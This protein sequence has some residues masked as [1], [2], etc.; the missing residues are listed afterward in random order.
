[1]SADLLADQF[2]ANRER[3]RALAYRMLGSLSDA[4]DAVQ[5]A[6]LRLQRADASAVQNLSAWLYTVVGRVCADM[7]RSRRARREEPWQEHLPEPIIDPPDAI[8]PEHQA[9]LT[10][11]VGLALLVVLDALPPDERL[12]YVLHD[13]FD[14]PFDD[15]AEVA[16]HTPASARQLASRARRRV[17][18]VATIPDSNLA[19]Q[20]QAVEAFLAASRAGDFDALV[21]VLD[22]D[23]EL[24]ADL[25]PGA[26]ARMRGARRV[27]KR[28]MSYAARA[29]GVEPA[30]IN[31]AAGLVAGTAQQV[32][33]VMGFIV[34][35]GR[36]VAID[37]LGD[38]ARLRH[39]NPAAATT[40][41]PPGTPAPA[42][43]R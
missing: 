26:L 27:A 31:G 33:T 35:N 41:A 12:A 37:I 39:L 9:L 40:S 4:D 22:P 3:L 5:E 16:G 23:V 17:Q 42:V 32:Y 43:S 24:R 28:A 19:R 29:V 15:I 11:A 1:M 10:D 38:P 21:A 8:D 2:E 13:M 36:V 20:R 14:V 18:R 34:Q 7:L 30:L 6:W 25:G